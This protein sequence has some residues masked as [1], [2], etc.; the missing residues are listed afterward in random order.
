MIFSLRN[1][2]RTT[3]SSSL[4]PPTYSTRAPSIRST[5]HLLELSFTFALGHNLALVSNFYRRHIRSCF[6]VLS[7]D[8][9][10]T[11]IDASQEKLQLVLCYT[12]GRE[13][14]TASRR[15]H[16]QTT[17]AKNICEHHICINIIP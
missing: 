5:N 4:P 15:H 7:Y 13:K 17:S 3:V 11:S 16:T 8:I 10:L 12:L 6:Y 1:L 14:F 9:L 2:H